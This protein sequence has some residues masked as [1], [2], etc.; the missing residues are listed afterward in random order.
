MDYLSRDTLVV[1]D[2]SHQ[3]IP[4]VR[5]MYHGD[6]SR[7][8]TLV[9]YGFRMPSALD[10]RPLNFSEFVT[11]VG[12]SIYVS[13][14]PGPYELERSE[15]VV[16]EQIIRPT[17]LTDPEVEVRPVTGQVDDLLHEIRERVARNER[18]LV[19][20]LT[21][22]MAEDL[23][24][25]YAEI[26]VKCR[27]LHS[28]IDTLERVKILRELRLGDFDVLIGINL[29]REGLDLPEVSLVAILD[30]DKE[31]FLRSG[32][33]LVQ[34]IGRAARNVEG[35]A[36]LY[37]D[38]ETDSMRYAIGE[39]GRRRRVQ[40]DYNRK[41]GITPESIVKSIRGGMGAAGDV[42]PGTGKSVAEEAP[43]F[44]SPQE[45]EREVERLT[46][47]MK[48]ASK[49]LEFEKAAELRDRIRELKQLELFET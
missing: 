15:G 27:Y 19:T 46:K 20:T 31:G 16:V 37:A 10:N 29:L 4:Q 22:R 8:E 34:T 36:I 13:A 43:L 2:E 5:G 11:R 41:H 49:E 32:G 21:K 23:T 30:A 40:E 18:V 25:Y 6:R 7:K 14:T 33:S 39:T 24:E 44:G 17:G 35:K 48:K 9:Q 26:G 45:I 28:D 1:I 3:T 42:D 12:Q 38:A 47:Q